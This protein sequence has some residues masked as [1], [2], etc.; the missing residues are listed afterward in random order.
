METKEDNYKTQE[1]SLQRVTQSKPED[2]AISHVFTAVPKTTK[3]VSESHTCNDGGSFMSYQ[4]EYIHIPV[5]KAMDDIRRMTLGRK[6]SI[7]G[8]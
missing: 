8:C 2:S 7:C 6:N 4:D 5:C 3:L 1:G